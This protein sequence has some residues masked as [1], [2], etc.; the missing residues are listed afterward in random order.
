LKPDFDHI[1][2]NLFQ[3]AA[4]PYGDAVAKLGFDTLVLCAKENQ[5]ED[6]YPGVEVVLAPGDD[7][8]REHRMMRDLPTWQQA[9]Q[10]VVDRVAAGKKVLVTC[11]AGL[12][13][14]GMVTALALHQ[15]TGWSGEDV[16]EHIQAS[17]DMALCNDTFAT[18]L[19]KL[20]AK[21]TEET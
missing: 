20:Q 2:E 9:A 13:R 1:V 4:P 11:M 10:L 19:R 15:I 6:L 21:P 12:N 5:R 18:H 14:S 16:V 17:R 7:D 8:C 3:G